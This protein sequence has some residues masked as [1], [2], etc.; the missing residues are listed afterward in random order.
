MADFKVIETQEQLDALI[1]DRIARAEK[2]A[3]E[4]AAKEYADYA[5][6]KEKVTAYEAQLAD[7]GKQ[8]TEA[9]EAAKG[10]STE[11]ADL[12]AKIKE[13]E[14]ASVKARI[15]NEI[16]LPYELASRLNGDSEEAIRQ[17]AETMAKFIAKPAAPMRSTEQPVGDSTEEAYR[18]LA[19]RLKRN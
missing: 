16:G 10:H 1:G 18:A 19:N 7:Y 11:V 14:T 12:Q 3:Q 5:S 8:L 17:D 2:K 9:K 4:N 6:L 13:Y 15:A